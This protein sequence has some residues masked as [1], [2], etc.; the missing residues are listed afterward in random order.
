M[1]KRNGKSITAIAIAA[2]LMGQNLVPV[3]AE[4]NSNEKA[5]EKAS[6]RCIHS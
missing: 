5:A 1:I 3:F 6:Q 4:V 2:T